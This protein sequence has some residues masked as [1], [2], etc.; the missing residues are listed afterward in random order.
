[1]N[2][3]YNDNEINIE[4]LRQYH[5]FIYKICMN[6][7]KYYI[8]KKQILNFTDKQ[9]QGYNSSNV[10]IK[11]N[12]NDIKEKTILTFVNNKIQAT[13][14]EVEFMIKYNWLDDKCLNNNML[15]KIYKGKL[16]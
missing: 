11:E 7:G 8:G 2:W 10:Y 14:F 3:K 1:M 16:K 12:K 4:E 9:I 15:G 6:D 5:S 13:Y